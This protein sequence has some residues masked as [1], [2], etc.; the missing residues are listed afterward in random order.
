MSLRGGLLGPKAPLPAAI[1]IHLHLIDLLFEVKTKNSSFSLVIFST[2]SPNI[3][4]GENG[5]I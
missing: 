4:F 1:N 3:N 5:L 2:L